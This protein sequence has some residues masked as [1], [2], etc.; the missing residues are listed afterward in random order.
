SG[1]INSNIVG[2]NALT[3]AGMAGISVPSNTRVLVAEETR[4]GKDIAFSIE[5]LS[6]I[7]GLYIV[8]N[9]EQAKTYCHQLLDLG[10]RGHTL[11]IHTN[12][13]KLAKEFAIEMPVSRVSV[14]TL[15]S[16]GAVGFTTAL[17]PTLTLGCGSYGGNI[18]SDNIT[19]RHLI[20]IKRMASGIKEAHIP[21]PE[22]Q[23][24]T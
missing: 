13:N 16:I 11:G 19:A 21:K 3:I 8:K 23:I 9:S 22:N 14:N 12:D 1:N 20:N 15:C 5:K 17:E 6:P 2:Q 18:T 7:L 24:S 4:V 10:G